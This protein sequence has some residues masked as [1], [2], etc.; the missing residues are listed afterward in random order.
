MLPFVGI[1]LASMLN[2]F[3]R[4]EEDGRKS[5]I[6]ITTSTMTRSTFSSNDF[7]FFFHISPLTFGENPF[8]PP[9]KRREN[10]KN[11]RQ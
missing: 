5:Q 9:Q 6:H 10:K 7:R 1:F 4:L 8:F 2:P 3:D 11:R